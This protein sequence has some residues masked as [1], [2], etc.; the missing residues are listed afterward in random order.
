MAKGKAAEQ[1][2]RILEFMKKSR[3]AA[4]SLSD[5]AL[6]AQLPSGQ[7]LTLLGQLKDQVECV[8]RATME[9]HVSM[10]WEDVDSKWRLLASS[11]AK[12]PVK[13]PPRPGSLPFGTETAA[14]LEAR[15][16]SGKLARD[17]AGIAAWL[18]H[19]GAREALGT[20]APPVPP[21]LAA[22]LSGFVRWKEA[23]RVRALGGA[24]R[25]ALAAFEA[26]RPGDERPRRAVE[27]ALSYA[28]GEGAP[29]RATGTALEVEK[30]AS[31]VPEGA[32]RFAA[33]AAFRLGILV[34]ASEAKKPAADL[35]ALAAEVTG[36]LVLALSEEEIRAAVREELGGWALS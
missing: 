32:A 35:D 23:T 8:S 16:K 17:R 22:W 34:A 3:G 5:I 12:A 13:W 25:R 33:M 4:V 29:G 24:T 27:A 21:D 30:A 14:E 19:A 11:G 31:E 10:K 20:L 7:V 15:M 18:G 2:Q 9:S 26:V 36:A 6:H 28:R 1:K